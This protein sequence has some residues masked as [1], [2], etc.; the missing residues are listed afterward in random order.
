MLPRLV[1]VRH[2]ARHAD[3]GRFRGIDDRA[4]P[5]AGERLACVLIAG[6]DAV[7]R[8]AGAIDQVWPYRSPGPWRDTATSAQRTRLHRA[9]GGTASPTG[10]NGG[11]S[12]RSWSAPCRWAG[13]GSAPDPAK[14]VAEDVR[15]APRNQP[16]RATYDHGGYVS[17]QADA[18]LT[19]QF[20]SANGVR[21]S[22][23]S[24]AIRP[25][26][27]A[28]RSASSGVQTR[29]PRWAPPASGEDLRVEMAKILAAGHPSLPADRATDGAG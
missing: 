1:V 10:P 26:R 9:R 6:A 24:R 18:H 27:Q 20:S 16:L 29:P 17:G 13:D 19:L 22:I 4:S 28:E 15:D 7:E 8:R 21:R 11:V 23:D 5:K 12:A 25:I 2:S 14:D 3:Y